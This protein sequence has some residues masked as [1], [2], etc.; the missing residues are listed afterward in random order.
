MKNRG[1]KVWFYLAN[2]GLEILSSYTG[3]R[4]SQAAFGCRSC[5]ANR[6]VDPVK[7]PWSMDL[8]RLQLDEDPVRVH[9]LGCRSSALFQILLY[10]RH[11]FSCDESHLVS[12]FSVLWFK[13]PFF[14]CGIQFWA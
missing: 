3:C 12:K 6:G 10:S 4:F 5:Q 11:G 8:A 13:L 1:Q 7:L 9:T 14:V 2:S